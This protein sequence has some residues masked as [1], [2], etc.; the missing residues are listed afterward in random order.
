MKSFL[1]FIEL[2]RLFLI[3]ILCLL[4]LSNPSGV[5]AEGSLDSEYVQGGDFKA[6]ATPTQAGVPTSGDAQGY[7]WGYDTADEAADAALAYCRAQLPPGP[8]LIRCEVVKLGSRLVPDSDHLPRLKEQ[9][10]AAVLKR[11]R[12]DLV[13]TGERE[14]ITRL[15]TIYQKIGRYADSEA[16]LY[17]LA[18]GGEHLAQNALAYHW[19]EL[20]KRL[21]EALALSDSAIFK[22]PGFFS[23]HDTRGLVL[24]RLERWEEA[25]ASSY[26]AVEL[27]AHPIA[28]DHYGDILWL[29]GKEAAARIQWERA[30]GASKNI[31]F[32]ER[33][34]AKIHTGMTGD[35]IF[36]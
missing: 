14:I 10:E 17:D 18:M 25:E 28:L 27:Q 29:R 34:R 31:L 33:V 2:N 35:I 19:A 16:L 3:A 6:M 8:R 11:L 21:D 32:I 23:Y 26:H 13:R 22:D 4:L 20:S 30:A 9:Y 15:S 36:E 24:V 12:A 7:A 1:E 5:S